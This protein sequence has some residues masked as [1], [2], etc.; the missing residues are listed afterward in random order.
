M[1]GI[2]KK[3]LHLFFLQYMAWD[4]WLEAYRLSLQMSLFVGFGA[5]YSIQ[6]C[7]NCM[8]VMVF[9]ARSVYFACC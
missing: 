5:Q 3:Y 9:F 8:L 1:G 4:F 2:C 6:V 7:I